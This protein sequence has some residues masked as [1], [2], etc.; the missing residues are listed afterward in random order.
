[1]RIYPDLFLCIYTFSMLSMHI[2]SEIILK[3]VQI[4]RERYRNAL[5]LI[6]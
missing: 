4:F 1:M 6:N 2:L 5:Y 3:L